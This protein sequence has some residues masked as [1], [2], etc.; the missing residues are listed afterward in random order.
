[1][2]KDMQSAPRDINHTPIKRLASTGIKLLVTDKVTNERVN[3]GI[4]LNNTT[5]EIEALPNLKVEVQGYSELYEALKEIT[6]LAPRDKL[7][8]PY[9]IQAVE[10]ADKAL[11]KA[12][13]K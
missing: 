11:A 6:E 9:A 2:N 5:L 1:M 7:R 4:Q 10:I 13:G 3:Y 12:E 8:L